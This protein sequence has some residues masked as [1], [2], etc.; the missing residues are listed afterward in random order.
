MT[1]KQKELL[2]AIID[3][4]ILLIELNL[5]KQVERN[6]IAINKAVNKSI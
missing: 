1:I 5:Y 4:K 2:G 6:F 3:L